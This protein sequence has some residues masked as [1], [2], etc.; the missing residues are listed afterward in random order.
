MYLPESAVIVGLPLKAG[1]LKDFKLYYYYVCL[2]RSCKPIVN[3][4]KYRILEISSCKEILEI[5]GCDYVEKIT[6]TEAEFEFL[7]H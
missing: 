1:L 4:I 7:N 6:T 2:I 3:S 5:S